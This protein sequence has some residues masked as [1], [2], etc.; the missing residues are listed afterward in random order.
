MRHSSKSLTRAL[1]AVMMAFCALF[2]TA[3]QSPSAP[4]WQSIEQKRPAE[5]PP[6]AAAEPKVDVSVRDGYIYI[7]ST[8]EVDVSVF[9]ILGQLVTSRRMQP[10]TMRLSLGTRGVY[11]LNAGP[12]TRRLNI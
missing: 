4:Q 7:T 9:T 12:V 2:H 6:L 10:G 8:D 1:T 11:I 3:A 5:R